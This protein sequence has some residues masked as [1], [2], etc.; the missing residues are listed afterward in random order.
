M[1]RIGFLL[2]I[3]PVVALAAV[4]CKK[5]RVDIW[6]DNSKNISFK[7]Q[8]FKK[9]LLEISSMYGDTPHTGESGTYRTFKDMNGDGEI[10][11]SEASRTE[12]LDLSGYKIR[13]ADELRYFT[14]LKVLYLQNNQLEA[15]DIT[16]C[17]ALQELNCMGN[18]LSSLDLR[19]N[20]T[21]TSL[22]CQYN[23]ITSLDVSDCSQLKSLSCE[24][25]RL[26]ILTL[27]GCEAMMEIDCSN[28]SLTTLDVSGCP[29]LITLNCSDNELTRLDVSKNHGLESLTCSGNPL[30]K[31]VIYKYYMLPESFVT[32]YEDIIE[33]AE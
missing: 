17:A 3:L 4:S 21:L 26:R 9:A 24:G 22:K 7:D 10:S 27:D 12:Y 30:E 5:D 11:E 23:N 13:N 15:I 19:K 33:T 28:N 6:V 16:N 25:N 29:N 2:I 18:T 14:S 31:L 20:T 1:K 32:S 8:R